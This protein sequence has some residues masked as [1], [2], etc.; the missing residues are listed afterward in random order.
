MPSYR[1]VL[2]DA[3][4][5]L[6]GMVESVPERLRGSYHRD[7]QRVKDAS[8]VAEPER[9]YTS[10]ARKY[11][12]DFR[13]A[14]QYEVDVREAGAFTIQGQDK[15]L[16]FLGWKLNTLRQRMAAGRGV[17]NIVKRDESTGAD[18]TITITRLPR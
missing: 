3:I 8:A 7:V 13:D 9:V 17:I 4:K 15:L 18:Q 10:G 11:W 5:L 14:Q 16:E 1:E 12:S 2:N 6:D